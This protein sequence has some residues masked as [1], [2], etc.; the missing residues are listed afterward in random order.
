MGRQEQEKYQ[1]NNIDHVGKSSSH[2]MQDNFLQ[3][4]SFICSLK[5]ARLEWK[6]DK[7]TFRT[8]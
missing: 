4:F 6:I 3:Y 5:M 7:D 2:P 1:F 8:G